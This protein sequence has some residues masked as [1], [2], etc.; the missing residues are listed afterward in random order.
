MLNCEDTDFSWGNLTLGAC[1]NLA[2]RHE[3][4]VGVTHAYNFQ[5]APDITQ[6]IKVLA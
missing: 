4:E 3:Q 1:Q 6:S 2:F 5:Q